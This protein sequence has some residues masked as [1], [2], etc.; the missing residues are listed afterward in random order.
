MKTLTLTCQACGAENERTLPY[1]MV[2]PDLCGECGAPF[3]RQPEPAPMAIFSVSID[4]ITAAINLDGS[5]TIT[6]MGRPETNPAH[7]ELLLLELISK[8]AVQLANSPDAVVTGNWP[9]KPDLI[10][11]LSAAASRA[12]DIPAGKRRVISIEILPVGLVVKGV[13]MIGG[14]AAN[15]YAT[16]PWSQLDDCPERLSEL[17]ERVG[18]VLDKRE[19]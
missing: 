1:N 2:A 18:A 11:A 7:R 16:M 19:G 8:M 9:R 4:S 15:Y 13:Q 6:R 5:A 10:S 14:S 12:A 3:N 17:V